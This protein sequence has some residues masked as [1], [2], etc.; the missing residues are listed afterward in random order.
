MTVQVLDG[1]EPATSAVTGGGAR[2][3]E[4]WR[5]LRSLGAAHLLFFCAV[6]QAA[7]WLAEQRSVRYRLYFPGELDI[8]FWPSWIWV[9][10]SMLV[11]VVIPPF[12]LGVAQ[13]KR[14]GMQCQAALLAACACF[15]LFPAELGFVRAIPSEMPYDLIYA[16]L[17]AAD[18]GN[19]LVPSLHV[20]VSTLC[21]PAYAGV[22]T[23][24]PGRLA[25]WSWL[26][27]IVASTLLVH[28][29]HLVDV[30]CG[31]A[32]AFLVRRWM[33]LPAVR[34]ASMLGRP[35]LDAPAGRT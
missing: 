19:N 29:H 20:A 16:C 10:A 15:L 11:V 5:C 21:L 9:Y 32:L 27:A 3:P 1:A 34:R 8:P 23:S 24:F 12:F 35:R 6:F 28:Q 13:V 7:S 2:T 31:L 14:L 30:V 25:L 18:R 22:T 33:P 26:G 17:F 4:T